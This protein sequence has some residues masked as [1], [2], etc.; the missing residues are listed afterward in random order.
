MVS[1]RPWRDL[2]KSDLEARGEIAL[3][4]PVVTSALVTTSF[5]ATEI[6]KFMASPENALVR[7]VAAG[8]S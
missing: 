2:V 5:V 3:L 8:M 4:M 6:S 7:A 1:G